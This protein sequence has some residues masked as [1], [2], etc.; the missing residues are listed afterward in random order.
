MRRVNTQRAKTHTISPPKAGS[1]KGNMTLINMWVNNEH[2]LTH[3]AQE[4][5]TV[6]IIHACVQSYTCNHLYT[7]TFMS[8]CIQSYTYI[9][10]NIHTSISYIHTYTIIMKLSYACQAIGM[11]HA[12]AMKRSAS[13]RIPSN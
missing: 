9:Q 4:M 5:A 11:H 13:T 10:L 3:Q 7:H 6:Q 8:T 1:T 12:L 2:L